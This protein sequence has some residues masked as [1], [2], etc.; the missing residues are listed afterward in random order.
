MHISIGGDSIPTATGDLFS[1]GDSSGWE[2][3]L[4]TTSSNNNN[5]PTESKLVCV[6]Y[7]A[8]L[9]PV[10]GN[11]NCLK[12]C[13]LISLVIFLDQLFHFSVKRSVSRLP[14][15]CGDQCVSCFLE[16]VRNDHRPNKGLRSSIIVEIS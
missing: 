9:N 3:A 12:H 5:Q 7:M 13:L 6:V 10:L 11:N 16:V 8:R 15:F 2:L 4:V 14:K 1:P